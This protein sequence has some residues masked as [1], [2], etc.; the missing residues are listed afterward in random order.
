MGRIIIPNSKVFAPTANI[1]VQGKYRL[2]THKYKSGKLHY[3]TGW[4]NN[5]ITDVGLY[6]YYTMPSLGAFDTGE[7]ASSCAVGSG[8]AA[9]TVADT[10][11]ANL[12]ATAGGTGSTAGGTAY[13]APNATGYVAAA[14]PAPAYWFARYIYQ[15]N[16]GIAAGNLT[17]VG[18]YPG[19]MNPAN[20]LLSRAL[21]VDANGN[22]TSI[23]VL[24]DEILTVTYELRYYL[25]TSDHAFSFNLNGSPVTGTYRLFQITSVPGPIT[26]RVTSDPAIIGVY[27]GDLQP[28]TGSTPPTRLGLINQS[29]SPPSIVQVVNDIANSGTCYIDWKGTFGTGNGTG[30][31]NSFTFQSHMWKYQFG[32]LSAPIIKTAGQQLQV[33]FRTSWGRF[34]G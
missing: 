23:T 11:L 16:T 20:N 34:S 33:N 10:G 7:V 29:T 32:L 13:A 24:S 4:F 3:D 15:F 5:L 22:P 31:I 27:N 18:A 1:G 6:E 19:G 2:Q 12:I 28:A 30:T 21:I 8:S 14:A 25:D 26:G 17:E 9:P